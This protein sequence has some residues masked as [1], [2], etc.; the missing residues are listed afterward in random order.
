[1]W[2]RQRKDADGHRPG[3][4]ESLRW[5]EGYKRVAEMAAD[6]ADTR[7]IYVAD[8]ESDIVELMLCAQELGTPADWLVRQTQPLP[9]EVRGCGHTRKRASL[10]VK[11][12]SP[13]PQDKGRKHGRFANSSGQSALKSRQA[14]RFVAVT[15]LC[16]RS[17]RSRGGHACSMA[18]IDQSGSA[19]AG[20]RHRTDRLV[21]SALGNR[22]VLQRPQNGCRIEAL[23]LSGVDRLERALALFMVVSWRIAR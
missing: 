11:W 9:S 10:S 18:F 15:V 8:R 23:Q 22:D 5:I 12:Y 19:R 6:V 3:A 2:A 20:R 1:M 13:W 16:Q 17:R 14:N 21:S 4:K 7:L